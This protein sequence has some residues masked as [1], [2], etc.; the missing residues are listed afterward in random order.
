MWFDI[1]PTIF[2]RQILLIVFI[3]DIQWTD[4]EKKPCNYSTINNY[5]AIKCR[6][7]NCCFFY[8]GTTSKNCYLFDTASTSSANSVPISTRS[9]QSSSMPSPPQSN[10]VLRKG[11][12]KIK[13][14]MKKWVHRL[15]VLQ[16]TNSL[17]IYFHPIN[18]SIKKQ[19]VF[20]VAKQWKATN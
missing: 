4:R 15:F 10:M 20:V 5:C 9:S 12:R 17:F 18:I 1:G 13:Q 16:I 7:Y 3:G 2:W 11:I 19:V 6:L 14:G 8:L